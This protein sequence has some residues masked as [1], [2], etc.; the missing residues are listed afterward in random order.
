MLATCHSNVSNCI[1]WNLLGKQRNLSHHRLALMLSCRPYNPILM[2]L[3]SSYQD[4]SCTINETAWAFVSVAT[5]CPWWLQN[6]RNP[7]VL[8]AFSTRCSCNNNNQ[9]TFS[10]HVWHQLY[11]F[12][13]SWRM[14]SISQSSSFAFTV[15]KKK[16]HFPWT[17]HGEL[18]YK[19]VHTRTKLFN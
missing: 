5:C 12:T 4:H 16:M 10:I 15:K 2:T 8:N 19:I 13:T 14:G 7:C 3:F 18:W 9:F 11:R 6:T 1:L 17:P